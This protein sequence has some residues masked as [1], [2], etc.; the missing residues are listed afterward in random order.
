M[1][2]S[3]S[4][5]RL[6]HAGR[7]HLKWL[8]YHDRRRF[9]DELLGHAITLP[10]MAAVIGILGWL[11]SWLWGG[12]QNPPNAA[13]GV[14]KQIAGFLI[15][16]GLLPGLRVLSELF[17]PVLTFTPDTLA[18]DDRSVRSYSRT[19]L[20]PIIVEPI[21]GGC[22]IVTFLHGDIDLTL[23]RDAAEVAAALREL[24]YPIVDPVTDPDAVIQRQNRIA[25]IQRRNRKLRRIY[26]W[27]SLRTFAH[28]FGPSFTLL[29]VPQLESLAPALAL[30]LAVAAV[31]FVPGVGHLRRSVTKPFI[32]WLGLSSQGVLL[33]GVNSLTVL[34]ATLILCRSL[35]LPMSVSAPSALAA[36]VLF[37]AWIWLT[38]HPVKRY[39]RPFPGLPRMLPVVPESGSDSH[40]GQ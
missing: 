37:V 4:S 18:V 31:W 21:E 30:V 9:L 1:Q 38:P 27:N 36:F 39:F 29:L 16:F 10:L 7:L 34:I 12:N 35:Q 14:G 23:R 8:L 24:G 40:A 33:A 22:R 11:L 20:S 32:W 19:T 5:I 13:L 17:R 2:D 3:D 26:S 28:Q 6:K 15:G 25:H